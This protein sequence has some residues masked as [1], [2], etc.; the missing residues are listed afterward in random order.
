MLALTFSSLPLWKGF[1]PLAI[2]AM[3]DNERKRHEEELKKEDA[4]DRGVAR[5]FDDS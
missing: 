2:L 4:E 3:S 5:L 1:D